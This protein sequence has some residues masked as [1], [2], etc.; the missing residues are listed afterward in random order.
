MIVTPKHIPCLIAFLLLPLCLG[1]QPSPFGKAGEITDGVL[2]NGISYYLV[3][4]KSFKGTADFAIVQQGEPDV[5]AARA[6]LKTAPHFGDRSPVRFLADHGIGYEEKGLISYSPA[7]TRFDFRDVP[8]YDEA[9]ADSTLMLLF[10]IAATN[11]YSQ[12]VVVSGDINPASTLERMKMFSMMVPRRDA[13]PAGAYEWSPRDSLRWCVTRNLSA[14]VAVINL[15]YSTERMARENL[16]TAVPVVMKAY[17]SEL[18]IVLGKR[19]SAAF[20]SAGVPLA[21]F[22][23]SYYDSADGPDD[24]RY[25][26]SVYTA[27]SRL[28]EAAEIVA[29]VLGT[30]DR[31]GATLEELQSARME[32]LPEIKGVRKKY[33]TTNAAFVDKCISSYLYGTSLASDDAIRAFLSKKKLSDD[34]ELDLFNGFS[35]A[36]LDPARNL[37]LRVDVPMESGEPDDILPV[38]SSSWEKDAPPA[39]TPASVPEVDKL[40]L[41]TAVEKIKLRGESPDPISGGKIWTFS[42]GMKVVFKKIPGTGTFDYGLM[43]RGG[44]AEVPGILPGEG[45][46]VSDMLA[47]S[48]V[49]GVPGRDF[50]S[51]LAACGIS[52]EET[53]GLSDMRITGS[54]PKEGIQTLVSALLSIAH[55]RQPDSDGF[56]YWLQ[57]EKLR[58]DMAALSP[59]D[60]NSLMDGFMYP[61]YNFSL[62]DA[63][64]VGKDFALRCG[65]YF[66]RQFSKVNDGV[67]VIVGDLEEETLKKLLCRTLGDFHTQQKISRR[68]GVS[69]PV[70]SGNSNHISEAVPGLVG[71]GELGASLSLSAD[72][73]FTLQNR[74]SFDVACSAIRKELAGVLA[75]YGAYAKV[76]G[77]MD[78]FPAERMT[79][80]VNIRS[81]YADGLPEGVEPSDP[82]T[83]P[84]A[85]RKFLDRLPS[86]APEAA[87]VNAWKASLLNDLDE[88]MARTETV[89]DNVILRYSG[90]KDVVAGYKNAVSSVSVDSVRSILT[91]LSEGGRVEY[92][93][94]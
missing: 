10:D 31:S 57:S 24:E 35:K 61:G 70:I 39:W 36:M 88:H 78:F 20:R 86:L 77:H 4:N 81:C 56:D 14:N 7:S 58:H 18:G 28:Q 15:I 75:D 37:T 84:E 94:L 92:V 49:A 55:D 22:R 72:I 73:P 60:M 80:Y 69:K 68:P 32:L 82:V 54:A 48:S 79:V 93:I 74:M 33:R 27:A 42:N 34:R 51:A 50:H 87:D 90:G 53:V 6:A 91:S 26:I 12:A 3:Q 2:P 16:G 45:A 29:S 30:L 76:S 21:D 44:F 64:A 13:A 43:L 11:P 83:L 9:V 38:F 1:G 52:M 66:S 40:P 19:L 25:R 89:V 62:R 85:I 41:Y 17:S 71:G 5:P 23:Y 65:D 47:G 8:V 46:F 59:R 67:F 63:S